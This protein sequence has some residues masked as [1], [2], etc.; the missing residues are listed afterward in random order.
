MAMNEVLVERIRDVMMDT[1]NLIE[2]KMF[3][4]VCFTINGYM[5]CG[6]QGDDLVVRVGLEQY[7]NALNMKHTRPMDFTGRPMKGYVYVATEGTTRKADLARWVNKGNAF[8]S[9]LPPKKPKKSKPAR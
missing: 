1:P 9:T 3:G 2:R 4:G 5:T 8:V 7:E 6:V